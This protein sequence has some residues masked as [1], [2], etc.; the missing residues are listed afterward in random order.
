MTDKELEELLTMFQT[1]LAI[2]Q[3]NDDLNHST[4]GQELVEKAIKN[5]DGVLTKLEVK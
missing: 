3:A 2:V 5:L 4:A 1:N